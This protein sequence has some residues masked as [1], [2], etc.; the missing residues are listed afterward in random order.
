MLKKFTLTF[1]LK[2]LHLG[3]GD[4]KECMESFLRCLKCKIWVS[5]K[6][7]NALPGWL[8]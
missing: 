7:E 6:E 3:G 8:P 5:E 2:K 1:Y 4:D